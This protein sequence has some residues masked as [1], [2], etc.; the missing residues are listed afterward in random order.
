MNAFHRRQL[1]LADPVGVFASTRKVS[2]RKLARLRFGLLGRGLPSVSVF[3]F[4]FA[5]RNPNLLVAATFG[6]GVWTY[7]FSRS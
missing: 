6:R 3:S 5:P 4:V 1:V 7:R 2:K